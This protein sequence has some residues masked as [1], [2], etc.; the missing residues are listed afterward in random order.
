MAGLLYTLA[1][2]P[3][4]YWVVMDVIDSLAVSGSSLLAPCLLL[5]V[6]LIWCLTYPKLD[7]W[8]T[9]RGDTTLVLGRNSLFDAC[10]EKTDLRVFVVAIPKG[11]APSF[12]WYDTDF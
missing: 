6:P 7:Y 12:F 1:M 2:M 3:V 10:H 8:S 11:W 4:Y 9:A 5:G